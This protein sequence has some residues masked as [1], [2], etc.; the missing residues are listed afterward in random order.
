MHADIEHSHRPEEIA[1]RLEDGPQANYLR[2][3][4]F[5]GIDG[6]VTTFAIVAGVA[7]AALSTNV[8]LILGA[9]NLLADGFSMA[10]GNYS[11]VKAEQD[12]Y[13][14][15]R[16]MELR[17]I[18]ITPEGER[19]EVRQI[20]AAKGFEGDDLER[21]VEI[22]TASHERWVKVMLEEEHGAPKVE[23]SP[24]IAGLVTFLAFFVCGAVPLVPFL[25]SGF[26]TQPHA[27][28]AAT[29]MTGAVFFGIGTLKSKWSTARWWVSGLETFAIGMV[30]AGTAYGVG[31]LL[32]SWVGV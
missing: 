27:M 1:K 3:W 5:G 32:K 11:G 6:A 13:H 22:I 4:V 24:K 9:A 31:A 10:A 2:D 7:G 14:R 17:H 21:A 28:I 18:A 16:E 25:F 8:I 23:R 15:L 19:E 30:A 26:I 12:D 20:F 29:I